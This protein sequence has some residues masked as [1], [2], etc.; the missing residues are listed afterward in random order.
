MYPYYKFVYDS[1]KEK[2]EVIIIEKL[3]KKSYLECSSTDQYPY[4]HLINAYL[5]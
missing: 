5:T 4:R 2:F 1:G 3:G